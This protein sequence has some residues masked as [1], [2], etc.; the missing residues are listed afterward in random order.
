MLKTWH[1]EKF[2]FTHEERRELKF[3]ASSFSG[4]SSTTMAG[5]MLDNTL[6]IP[7][8]VERACLGRAQSQGMSN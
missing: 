5:V 1:T 3:V 2:V 4:R 7:G 8:R 6:N